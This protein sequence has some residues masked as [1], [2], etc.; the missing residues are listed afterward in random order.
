MGEDDERGDL[1]RMRARQ[2]APPGDLSNAETRFP[3][4]PRLK[5]TGGKEPVAGMREPETSGPMIYAVPGGLL[6]CYP[7]TPCTRTLPGD[8][9]AQQQ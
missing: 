3:K 8:F 5:A 6:P 2:D 1:G 4:G 7:G 9:R